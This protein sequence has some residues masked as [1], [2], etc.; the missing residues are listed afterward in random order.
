MRRVGLNG[1]RFTIRDAA[2]EQRFVRHLR[3]HL[4][5]E[6]VEL[7]TPPDEGAIAPRAARLPRVP[8]TLTIVNAGA[9]E[10]LADWLASRGRLAGR[11]MTDL[12]RLALIATPQF[13]IAIGEFAGELAVELNCL[14]A[15][16]MRTSASLRES[17]RPLE[18]AARHS[19][20]VA[21]ALVAALSR[22]SLL[23]RKTA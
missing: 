9:W 15:N 7:I 23:M 12:A 20:R 13:A 10:A 16:P 5:G 22:S 14:A 17:L 2:C 21:D 8:E 4:P 6:V 1:A 3:L 19:P 11:T 18:Q